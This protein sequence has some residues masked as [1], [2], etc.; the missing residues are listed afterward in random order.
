MEPKEGVDHRAVSGRRPSRSSSINTA[1]ICGVVTINCSFRPENEHLF[2]NALLAKMKRGSYA[3][4]SLSQLVEDHADV[5]V[6]YPQQ[7]SERERSLAR[8]LLDD[9]ERR[10][11]LQVRTRPRTIHLSH[12]F[13]RITRGRYLDAEPRTLRFVTMPGGRPELDVSDS[14]PIRFNLSHTDGLVA[15]IGGAP[16]RPPARR[17][18]A[19]LRAHS[20]QILNKV[21]VADQNEDAYPKAAARWRDDLDEFL[22]CFRLKTESA[23]KRMRTKNAI[24]RAVL[25]SAPKNPPHDGRLSG[26]D[27]QLNTYSSAMVRTMS[28]AR[29]ARAFFCFFSSDGSH[30]AA[31][32]RLASSRACRA[33][34]KD[35]AG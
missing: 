9:S 31:R 1:K 15:C 5:V 12:A 20:P 34:A 6:A 33:S 14:S 4:L 21:R 35:I 8:E 7:A 23:R 17:L 18:P 2:K 26:Q 11:A 28:L 10:Q 22:T 16:R 3:N 13:L 29:S 30:P 24:E 19:L 25:R 27:Q 32:D